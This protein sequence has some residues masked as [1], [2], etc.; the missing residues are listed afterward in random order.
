MK[1]TSKSTHGPPDAIVAIGKTILD[2]TKTRLKARSQLFQVDGRKLAHDYKIYILFTG[3]DQFGVK[4]GRVASIKIDGK[5][6]D[7]KLE[8]QDTVAHNIMAHG[9]ALKSVII[10]SKSIMLA[11]PDSTEIIEGWI[12]TIPAGPHPERAARI[13]QAIESAKTRATQAKK[14]REELRIANKA[15]AIERVQRISYCLLSALISWLCVFSITYVV[16]KLTGDACWFMIDMV[17]RA[18]TSVCSLSH[19]IVSFFDG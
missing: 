4:I 14:R 5:S 13:A 8:M 1:T 17:Y 6:C 16:L 9:H 12:D 7:F 11:D 2:M 10:S 3:K 18:Y 19:Q 15:K